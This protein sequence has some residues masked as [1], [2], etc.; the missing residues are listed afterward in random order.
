MRQIAYIWNTIINMAK[1]LNALKD[2]SYQS[3]DNKGIMHLIE[4]VRNGISSDIFYKVILGTFSFSIT[5]WSTY[6]HLSERTM[7]RYRTEKKTFEPI[8]SEKILEITML[9]NYGLNVFGNKENFNT[10]IETKNIALGGVKPKDLLDT[11][12]GI[13]LLKDELTRI[14]HGVLA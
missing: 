11:S 6:L 10:W 2:I 7:Q 9:Y 1:E 8:Q 5:E 12:Y 3:T 14:E 13:G 4:Q